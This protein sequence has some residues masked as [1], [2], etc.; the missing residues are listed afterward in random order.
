MAQRLVRA[1]AKIREAGIPYRVPPPELLD[2][3]IE[4]V[5]VVIYL[6]FNEGYAASA[7]D[8]LLR[9]ELCAEAIHLARWLVQLMTAQVGDAPS[10]REAKGLLALMLAHD[11][12][13]EARIG[14]QGE[15]VLLSDQDRSRFR[16]EPIREAGA[17]VEE[18]LRGGR[19][20]PYTLQAAIAV[21]HGQAERAEE[22]DWAQIAALY[23]ILLRVQ[24]TPIVSL[25]HAVA[26]AMAEGPE[27][28]LVLL[29]ALADSGALAGYHLLPAARA[30][31]LRRLGRW[32]QAAAAYRAALPLCSNQAERGFLE[33]RLT[34]VEAAATSQA[35]R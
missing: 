16:K 13:A 27:R 26:V 7:G 8:S 10:C 12:R 2:E 34:E 28:G 31:L 18:A 4:S 17:L 5:M 33:R 32:E 15:L 6:V 20:G 25:N 22:T 9:R 11:A 35:N 21:L 3:R 14:P 29:D 24:P 1:K 30:D 23:A 19:P